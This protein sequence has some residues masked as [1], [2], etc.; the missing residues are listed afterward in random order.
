MIGWRLA[1]GDWRLAI[2]SWLRASS[3]LASQPL[4]AV[5]AAELP[6]RAD[7]FGGVDCE[8]DRPSRMSGDQIRVGAAAGLRPLLTEFTKANSALSIRGGEI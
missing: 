3:A 4:P 7:L 6:V 2:G 1:I 8:R 5:G